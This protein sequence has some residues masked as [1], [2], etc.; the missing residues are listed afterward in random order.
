MALK[1]LMASGTEAP[2]HKCGKEIRLG[3][4]IVE[5]P[6]RKPGKPGTFTRGG[7]AR[8]Y[9]H[10]ECAPTRTSGHHYKQ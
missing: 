2:C 5:R 8:V 7:K 4:F 10:E 6:S 9:V 1:T 3:D